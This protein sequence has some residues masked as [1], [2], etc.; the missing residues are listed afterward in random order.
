MKYLLDT[1]ILSQFTKPQ[2]DDAI[3]QWLMTADTD[4]LWLSTITLFEIRVGIEALPAG[5]RK[6][7][8]ARWLDEDVQL[9]YLDRILAVDAA[10]ANRAA[11]LV[12]QARAEGWNALEMDALIAATALVN[13]MQVATM[14][15]KHFER[16][17]V[18]LVT[19]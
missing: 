12:A 8:L 13:G 18:E 7:A 3:M 1:N 17:G 10:V 19:F 16:L 11:L 5:K 2:P 14:N 9:E 6:Q 15:Q 4:S